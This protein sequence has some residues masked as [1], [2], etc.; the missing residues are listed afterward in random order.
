MKSIIGEKGQVTI[1]KAL[2]QSLGMFPGQEVEFEEIEGKLLLKRRSPTRDPL[3]KLV[4]LAKGSLA[5]KAS[6]DELLSEMRGPGFQK[7]L[8][9]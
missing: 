4:G 3:Q 7:R 9:T 8:D 2:R 1:P 6:T 5:A